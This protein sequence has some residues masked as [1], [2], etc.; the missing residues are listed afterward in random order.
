M[1]TFN[2]I[3]GCASIISLI[4]SIFV[5]RKV[6]KIDNSINPKQKANIG[7]MKDSSFQQAG[8]DITNK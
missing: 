2:I 4:I 5:I 1:N 6:N 8:R 7:S 3:A